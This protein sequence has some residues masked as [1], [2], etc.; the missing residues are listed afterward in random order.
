MATKKKAPVKKAS[1][2]VAKRAPARRAP[3]ALMKQ[4]PKADPPVPVPGP[5][6]TLTNEVALGDLG[7]VEMRFTDEEERVLSTPFDLD[8]IRIK[9]DGAVYISHPSYTRKMNQAFGRTGWGL[10]PAS[11][12]QI[13]NGTVVVPY[14]LHIHG[15]PVAFAYGEQEFHA[16]NKNQSYGDAIEATQASGLRRVC[17]RLGI[18]LE[19]WDKPF[20]DA[21]KHEHCVRV[22]V[23][24][25][26]KVKYQWRRKVDP[27]FWNEVKSGPRQAKDNPAQRPAPR[28]V[29]TAMHNPDDH[30]P[31]TDEQLRRFWTIA[32]RRGRNEAEIKQ[33]LKSKL[34]IE[35][36]KEIQ[37]RD[38]ESCVAW[39]EH[40][41][42]QTGREPGSDDA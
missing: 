21:F 32:R 10:V 17:K 13:G 38:Y 7:L 41:T 28:D 4:A 18:A 42:A 22:G 19:L 40:P 3:V 26:G 11:M 35:H 12:P 5:E 30:R 1:T 31:I 8:D 37:R 29:S 27:P 25:D 23:E 33:Y 39:L 36:T 15:K 34:N 16:N 20:G 24:A 14:R 9:P 2:A 6:R